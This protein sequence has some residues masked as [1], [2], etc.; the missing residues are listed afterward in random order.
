MLNLP[1]RDN[2]FDVVIE[3]GTIEHFLLNNRK[4]AISEIYRVLKNNGYFFF[5]AKK[6]GDYLEKS[7]P[8][9]EENT[10]TI[11]E[12]FIKNTPYHF[13]NEKEI[14]QFLNKFRE[15]DLNY[16][17]LSRKNMTMEI[18]NWIIVAQK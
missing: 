14:R 1:Y 9:V 3:I 16:E 2:S 5:I 4:K 10:Y 15:I 18:H 7:G 11:N 8:K 13:F 17:I 12:S 6:R